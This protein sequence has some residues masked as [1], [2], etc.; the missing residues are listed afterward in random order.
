MYVRRGGRGGSGFN[1]V[2]I[3]LV[4]GEE[5]IAA[6]TFEMKCSPFFRVFLKALLAILSVERCF[7]KAGNC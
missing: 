6:R 5:L 7:G 4:K 1:A 3:N 2:I